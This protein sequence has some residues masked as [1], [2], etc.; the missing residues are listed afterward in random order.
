MKALDPGRLRHQITYQRQTVSGQNTFGEDVVAWTN[1][2]TLKAEV[3][4]LAG[5]ELYAVAQKWA[6]ARYVIEHHYY[7]GLKPEDRISWY[8]DGEVKTLDVLDVQ[9]G[10]GAGR[11]QKV[12]AK[13]HIE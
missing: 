5:R 10:A 2:V 4:S 9:D 7:L 11:V 3:R 8:V 6:E 1:I 12:I 13:D